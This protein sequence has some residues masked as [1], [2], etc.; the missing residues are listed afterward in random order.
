MVISRSSL[1]KL[2]TGERGESRS[3]DTRTGA[4]SKKTTSASSSEGGREAHR[5]RL[6]RIALYTRGIAAG[7]V[8]LVLALLIGFQVVERDNIRSG[9]HAYGVDLGGM[10]YDEAEAAL[11]DASDERT[12]QQLRLTD[13]ASRWSMTA[14]ELGLTLNPQQ[15]LDDAMAAGHEGFGASRLAVFWHLRS[16]PH[17]VG[18][19]SVAV[20]GSRL[21]GSLAEIATDIFQE[22][23]DPI[24]EVHNGV[25]A[26]RSAIVGRQLNVQASRGDIIEALATGELVVPLTIDE[27]QPSA[28]DADF[29]DARRQLDNALSGAIELVTTTDV[30]TLE[31]AQIANWM[32]IH[33]ARAGFPARV[34]VD[35]G[36][37]EAVVWEISLGTD[38]SPQSPRVWWDVGGRLVVTRE[39]TP[40]YE[41]ESAAAR[42]MIANAFEGHTDSNR[43]DL[44]VAVTNLPSLPGDLGTLGINSIIAQSST[45]Y[46]GG[47][48]ERM[49]NIELAAR[50][51]TGT[52]IMP[53]QTFSFNAEIGDMTLDAGFQ[54]GYG[55]AQEADGELR[56]I[57]A[58]AGGICQV[59]TTVFQPVFWTGYQI[60]QRSTHFFWIPSYAYNGYV[61]M[62][63]T[64]EPAAGLDLKW[65]N[66][67]ST[68]VL[69]EATADGQNFSVILYGSAPNWRVEIDEPVISNVVPAEQETVYEPSP[70]IPNGTLRR[71]E[72]AQDGFEVSITRRVITG[73]D[74]DTT[75]LY[76]KYGPSRSVVLVGSE[77]G[78]LPEGWVPPE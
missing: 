16:D 17:E 56:T 14:A 72:R 21:E 54:I 47:L 26:Y 57:P 28:Y 46:G 6:A 59:S 48:P 8:V 39:G 12:S 20:H 42:E 9:V 69:L 43:L 78:E 13:G 25:P 74:V 71:I 63:S 75:T 37:I 76:A 77:T 41:L 45:P 15:A 27:T 66:N 60:D 49:H 10:T 4:A 29:A 3:T 35:Q 44:P 19:D 33:Q 73:D 58:E 67:S 38:R 23:V 32:T 24:L 64:V 40:G 18:L 70:D 34:E 68:A 11:Q 30:W 31:P 52:L 51:L 36:W 50:L 2:L 62:D 61:G 5:A 65:T 1:A 22:K 7:V 55:I 53:G